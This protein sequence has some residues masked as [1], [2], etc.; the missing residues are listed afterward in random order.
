MH[1]H[2]INPIGKLLKVEAIP[3]NG[4]NLIYWSI[5]SERDK[6]FEGYK[7]YRS[8]DNGVTWGTQTFKDFDGGLHFVPLAQF[9]K[10]DSIRGNYKTIPSFA[11]FNLGNESDLPLLKVISNEDTKFFKSG[12][13]VRVFV[14]DQ[15]VNGQNYR[16]YIAAYDTGNGI[17]GPLENTASST[18]K[19]GTNTI[20]VVPNAPTS[21]ES[22]ADVRV[23][24]NP[25]IIASGWE[26]GKERILQFTHMPSRATIK[27]FNVAGEL[28][29]TIEHNSSNSIA[30]S[31]AV[32]DLKNEDRQL[33]GA[34]LY[35]YYL[36]SDIGSKQGKF[37]VIQ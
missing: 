33:V 12:D 16:Y 8:V 17:I 27:I 5:D 30:T 23:V 37:I 11:W 22:L 20:E 18:P 35:F 24:P 36:Q 1:Y 15:V 2:F 9:D 19:I 14:D 7:I 4:K 28:V 21:I 32:W 26:T 3:Q 10:V 31:I 13:S 25:Y 6:E 29:R 34:G